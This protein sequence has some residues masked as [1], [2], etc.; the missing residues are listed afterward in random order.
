[1]ECAYCA[2]VI[3]DEALA[4]KHCGRDLRAVRPVVLEI[5]EL[6][7]E[8]DSLQRKLDRA[9][10][11]LAMVE[12]PVASLLQIGLFYA[13]VPITLLIVTH[14]VLLFVLDV[15]PLYLRIASLLI[16]L[17][18]GLALTAIRKFELVGA[19]IVAGFVAVVSVAGMLAVSSVVDNVPMLPANPREWR[20]ASEYAASIA[21][22]FITGHLIGFLIFRVL[23]G[24]MASGGKPNAA[25]YRMA[26][27]MGQ[28]VGPD[29]LRRRA[30]TV[31]DLM[32]TAGPLGGVVVTAGGSIYT[33]L[34][35]IMLP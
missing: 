10:N 32:R 20:E 31:Q 17:P 29:Q 1:M 28:H 15:P 33:G 8:L 30:R 27:L 35:A 2:E 4:C 22:S 6:V 14:Y 24:V 21:L 16:P 11:H 26:R 13:L 9:R 7:S 12:R 23:P 18:F 19:I 34:K 5:Q 3:R 25:A